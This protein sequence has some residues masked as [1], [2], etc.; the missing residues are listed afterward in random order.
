A[1]GTTG[2]V[3]VTAQTGCTWSSTSNDA[4]ITFSG[5]TT[6]SGNGAINYAVAANS[7]SSSRTGTLTIAGQTFTVTQ[8]GVPCSYAISPTSNPSVVAGGA[9]GTVNVTAPTGCTWSST[10]NDAWI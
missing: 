7:S 4:W 5:A 6:G 3:G 10:S 1:A 9:T 2:S 8:A